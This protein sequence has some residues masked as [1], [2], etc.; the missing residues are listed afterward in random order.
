MINGMLNHCPVDK[1]LNMLDI[2]QIRFDFSYKF[3]HKT[4]RP[5]VRLKNNPKK[6]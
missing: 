3:N 1:A 5:K 4:N 6:M 2:L